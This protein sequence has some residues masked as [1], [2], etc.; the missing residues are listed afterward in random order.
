MELSMFKTILQGFRYFKP[1]I[2]LYGGEPLYHSRFPEFLRSSQDYGY[3]PTLTTNGDYLEEYSDVILKSSVSQLNISVNG[4]VDNI[5]NLDFN[6]GKKI[7]YFIRQNQ[8]KKIINLNCMLDPDNPENLF[9]TVL[10]LN[11][12]FKR[13][14]FKYFVVQHFMFNKVSEKMFDSR[15][16]ADKLMEIKKLNLN[17]KLIYLPNIKITDI[18]NY[19][20][21]NYA[22]RNK[23]YI[24]WFGVCVYPDLNVTAG[25]GVFGCNSVLGN[26]SRV[27]ILEIWRGGQFN[28]LRIRILKEG[29]PVICNRCCHKFYY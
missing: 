10:Y 28:N 7:K 20:N 25:A 23:C 27:S 4:L 8:R 2:H 17:F 6:F 26:L 1:H 29:L 18:D 11:N 15:K 16:I 21:S 19:Y 3:S 9:D 13:G 12:N 5:G 22:F 24:P 14:D